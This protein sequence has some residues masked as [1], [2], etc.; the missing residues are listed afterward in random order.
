MSLLWAPFPLCL[1]HG[2]WLRS[3]KQSTYLFVPF[4]AVV[5]GQGHGHIAIKL[6]CTPDS[7]TCLPLS[8]LEGPGY[9][10]YSN[11]NVKRNKLGKVA[12]VTAPPP[13]SLSCISHLGIHC[14]NLVLH[15]V[16]SEL[17]EAFH[18]Q[19]ASY[20]VSQ[21]IPRG[22]SHKVGEALSLDKNRIPVRL[23]KAE[24][25]SSPGVRWWFV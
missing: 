14:E 3:M 22:L 4:P 23:H 8:F 12:S 21:M 16:I 17:K 11:N 6:L 25:S 13:P 7:T 2:R 10:W 18:T 19:R 24:I 5:T 1:T 9:H 20:K 15:N